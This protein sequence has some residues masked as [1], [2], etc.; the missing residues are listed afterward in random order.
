[1]EKSSVKHEAPDL[2]CQVRTELDS[3]KYAAHITAKKIGTLKLW[4]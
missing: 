4:V 1:M 2:E 3:L